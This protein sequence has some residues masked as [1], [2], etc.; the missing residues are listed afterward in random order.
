MSRKTR[1]VPRRGDRAFEWDAAS[2]V[3]VGLARRSI[4]ERLVWPDAVVDVAEAGGL[5]RER[6]AVVDRGAVEVLVLQRAE[7]SLDDAV[8]LRAPEGGPEVAQQRL[9][10][11]ERRLVGL[12]A[13]ARAVVGDDGDRS[14]DDVDELAGVLVDQFAFATVVPQVVQAEN[15]FGLVDG[16]VETRERIDA[17]AGRGTPCGA[18]PPRT[19]DQ[20]ENPAAAA[21]HGGAGPAR[22]SR[23]TP[24]GRRRAS[25]RRSCGGP[26]QA[27]RPR[28]SPPGPRPHQRPASAT[29]PSPARRRFGAWPG[30]GGRC[31]P[32]CRPGRR[33]SRPAARL[34]LSGPRGRRRDQVDVL[35]A[36]LP[37]P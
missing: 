1:P 15:A 19:C 27:S 11:G 6:A 8:G 12:A 5:H 20:P 25:S 17:A 21:A 18:T 23:W 10:A 16:R 7:A 22:P 32:E 3:E 34:P 29:A 28:T 37:D 24:D 26:T 31:A 33:T 36:L 35:R 2:R 14:G 13:K 30:G 4:V 9:I